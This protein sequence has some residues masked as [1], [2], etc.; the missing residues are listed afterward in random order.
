MNINNK[1]V[2]TYT[3]IA[4]LF[5]SMI[6][7]AKE[8]AELV[9]SK[10]LAQDRS[11]LVVIDAGHG[12]DDAGKVGINGAL[13]KDINLSIA[14]RLK[15]LLEQQDVTV[16]MTREDDQGTYPKTGSNRKMRDMKKR[17]EM[18]NK[19]QPAL[20]VSIHQNS[21]TDAS[22]SGAQTFFYQGSKEGQI[23]AELLQKQLIT[24][25]QPNKE[26]SAKANDSYYLL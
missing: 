13:E 20:V 12:A 18:I 6:I 25:L 8:A 14:L 7:V 5:L 16:V 15:E 24:T 1:K 9:V 11:R 17:I 26:R 4:L 21:F 22:V 10:H 23:A 19:E 3:M 2:V